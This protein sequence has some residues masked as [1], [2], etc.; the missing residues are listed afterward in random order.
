[1]IHRMFLIKIKYIMSLI[2][3]WYLTIEY[4]IVE[5]EQRLRMGPWSLMMGLVML[6]PI[7]SVT[8]RMPKV[9]RHRLLSVFGRVMPLDRCTKV[10]RVGRRVGWL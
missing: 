7:N 10:P 1:M 3:D 9:K 5:L 2:Y 4:L 8:I 6:Q